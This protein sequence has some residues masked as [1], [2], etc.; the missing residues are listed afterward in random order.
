[1]ISHNVEM[2][3]DVTTMNPDSMSYEVLNMKYVAIALAGVENRES[4]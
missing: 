4:L 1:M 2:D 3:I